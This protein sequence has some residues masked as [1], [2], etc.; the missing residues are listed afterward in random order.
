M[1]TI[2]CMPAIW[3][4]PPSPRLVFLL[5]LQWKAD[6]VQTSDL[7][8]FTQGG[9]ESWSQTVGRPQFDGTE[10]QTATLTRGLT[11]LAA[12]SSLLQL[13]LARREEKTK[14]EGKQCGSGAAREVWGWKRVFMHRPRCLAMDNSRCCQTFP[15]HIVHVISGTSEGQ[16]LKS[17]NAFQCFV[18][19]CYFVLMYIFFFHNFV[20]SI[21][22]PGWHL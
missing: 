22:S 15:L 6:E 2:T 12:W 16:V 1:Q 4:L 5:P 21:F 9:W 20:I 19:V 10:R 3:E 13:L 18:S 7:P 11:K 14:C 17:Q 8:G